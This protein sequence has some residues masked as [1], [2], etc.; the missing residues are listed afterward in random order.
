MYYENEI[1]P[2]FLG[3]QGLN[4]FIKFNSSP[5]LTMSGGHNR[6]RVPTYCTPKRV[7][8][9]LERELGKYNFNI[10]MPDNGRIVKIVKAIPDN[11]SICPT[12]F[13]NETIVI[14]ENDRTGEYDYFSLPYS[15]KFHQ[16]FSFIYKYIP[17]NLALIR[18][19][20]SI[21][22]DTIFATPPSAGDNGEYNYGFSVETAYV[23]G[24]P[25]LAEDGFIISESLRDKLLYRREI[26]KVIEFGRESFPINIHGDEN[27]YKIFPDIGEYLPPSGLVMV[28]RKYPCDEFFS[29]MSRKDL[30]RIDPV[31]DRPVYGELGMGRVVSI[32]VIAN[33]SSNKNIPT[34]C[35][36]QLEKYTK[37]FEIYNKEILDF[38]NKVTIERYRDHQ[39]YNIKVSPKL[40]H[41]MVTSMAF[42][43][44]YDKDK[45][46]VQ[47]LYKKKPLD[48]YRVEITIEYISK[49]TY[50]FKLTDAH[51]GGKGVI[52]DIWPDYRMLVDE[53]GNRADILAASI[54]VPNRTNQ[55][56]LMDQFFGAASRDITADIR[57]KLLGYTV[58]TVK[59]I[60]NIPSSLFN[61]CYS[62]LLEYYKLASPE[63]YFEHINFINKQE[64]EEHLLDVINRGIFLFKNYSSNFSVNNDGNLCLKMKDKEII[65]LVNQKFNLVRGPVY[66]V[67]KYG[68][69]KKTKN[70][71]RIGEVYH[72]MLENV[73]TDWSAV[74]ISKSQHFGMLSPITA[75]EKFTLPGRESPTRT[76]GETEGR[77]FLSYTGRVSMAE[78]MDRA[79]NPYTQYNIIENMWH[80]ETPSNMD[81]AVDRTKIPLGGGRNNLLFEHATTIQG[82]KMVYRPPINY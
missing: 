20:N 41:L 39:D 70:N 50:G 60:A 9:G 77:L 82:F 11:Y 52:C 37:A 3:F 6:A 8:T 42:S 57:R 1:T 81:M 73:P 56:K 22:K 76:V 18:Y 45:S 61:E 74:S 66:Y 75:S 44:S 71:I 23:D 63:Q 79:N 26:T 17:E 51:Y 38:E 47:L 64:S 36:P 55:G 69:K 32:K 19:G 13:N 48:E 46:P 49:A 80:S 62:L 58:K 12:Q 33:N 14:F 31:F 27:N 29:P 67:D 10:V 54:S 16:K 72:I 4:P 2:E 30:M 21:K 25:E 43:K 24:I 7:Q 34:I 53:A 68:Q 78:M 15:S 5:R 28:T 65:K 35:L 59:D 40:H